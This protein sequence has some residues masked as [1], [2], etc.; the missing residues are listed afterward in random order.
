MA[1]A[2][3]HLTVVSELN[4]SPELFK[5]GVFADKE[6]GTLL[7][8][9]RFFQLGAISPDY[10]YLGL[11]AILEK[12][13]LNAN[14]ISDMDKFAKKFSINIG[15]PALTQAISRMKAGLG[16]GSSQEWANAMH[17]QRTGDRLK[18]GIEY[19]KGMSGE[20]KYKALAWL[21]GFA[22]HIVMDIAIHPIVE[23][24]VGPYNENSKAHTTCEMHQDVF[25][26][27]RLNIGTP[28][29]SVFLQGIAQ[30]SEP[31][32]E[33]QLD[34]TICKVWGHM[35]KTTDAQLYKDKPPSF[36]AWHEQY[37]HLLA[38]AAPGPKKPWAFV[39]HQGFD[40]LMYPETPEDSY[41]KG[42]RTPQGIMSYTD[43]FDRAK[44]QVRKYWGMVASACL[45][46]EADLS[47]IKNW[48]LDTGRDEAN[49]LTCWE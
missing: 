31:K 42:L 16:I 7:Q 26:Y 25:I 24:K 2:Y 48:N 23:L 13:G 41:I 49:L 37:R 45:G 30:C 36:H 22:S 18:A 1:G 5:L 27:K 4:R 44:G 21:L 3:A 14:V 17:Y 19:V 40:G 46:R 39:R 35:L 32:N 8:L 43:I 10:P 38:I 6:V 9:G 12:L 47:Q 20:E 29:D 28:N 15:L 11:E 34:A 33:N